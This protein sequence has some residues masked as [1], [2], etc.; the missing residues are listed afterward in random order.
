MV[1]IEWG[2]GLRIPRVAGQEALMRRSGVWPADILPLG[3]RSHRRRRH[4]GTQ[5]IRVVRTFVVLALLASVAAVSSVVAP[6]PVAADP[7]EIDITVVD[8]ATGDPIPNFKWVVNLDN[9]HDDASLTA[10]ASYSSV[11]AT[12]EVRDGSGVAAGVMLDDTVDPDRGYLVT[13]FVN[14]GVGSLYP[15]DYKIGGAHFR[16]PDAD[17]QVV[18][19]LQANPLPLATLK[20]QVFHDNRPVNGEQDV[21][22]E[23][24][25][26][27][28]HVT[29][30]DRVGEVTTDWFGNPICTQYEDLNGDGEFHFPDDLDADGNPVPVAGTGGVCLTGPDGIATIPNLGP[31]KYEA[32]AIPPDGQGWIQT[33]TIEGTLA[34]DAWIQEGASGFA[35]EPEAGFFAQVWF[36]F[37]HECRFGSTTDDCTSA[38][39]DMSGKTGIVKGRVRSIV[40]DNEM[41]P[42]TMGNPVASPY[43]AL[44]NIGGNDEQVWTG[45]GNVDGSFTITGVPAGLY[46]M[47]IWDQPIDHIIQFVTVRVPRDDCTT[48]AAPCTVDLGDLGVPPWFGKIAGT[49]YIDANEDGIRNPGE[50]SLPNQDLDT[51]FKD[52]TIQYTAFADRNGKYEF[53]EVF[54]LEHFAIAEVGY[55]RFKQTGAAAYKTDPFGNP[56]GYPEGTNYPDGFINQDLGLASLLQAEIT[57]AGTTNYI[58]WGKKAFAP[59]EN[60]GIVGIVFNATTRNELDARLQA[61]EDYEPGVPNTPV[62]LYAPE[63]DANGNPV[64]DADTG[65]IVKDHLAA[66]YKGGDGTD[67]W[68]DDALPKDCIPTPSLGRT[69]DQIQPPNLFPDCVELPSLF[70]QVRPGVFDGGYAFDLDCS[71]PDATDPFDPDQLLDPEADQC[72]PI[73]S[74]QWVVE[75]V[76][77]DGYGVVKEEDV[78]VFGG[79]VFEPAIPPPPCAGAQHTVHVVDDPADANFDPDDPSH[80]TGV[81]NPDFL[82]T[83]SPLAPNGGSPYEGQ[84]KPLCNERLVDLADG[85]N[86]NSDFFVFTDVPQPGRI[87]GVLLD[88]L[89]LELDPASP[90][91]GEKRG[92]PNAPIGIRDFTGRLVTTVYSDEN[93]YWEVLL[94][95]TGTYNCPLP[96][97]P[98]P[99]MYYVVGNDPGDIQNPDPRYDPNYQTLPL[100]FEVWPATTTYADVAT[101]PITGFVQTPGTQFETP[102]RC[103]VAAETPDV[104]AVSQPYGN[105]GDSFT[106]NGTGF[107]ATEGTVKLGSAALTV[108]SW[109]DTQIDVTVPG[110]TTPGPYQLTVT[111]SGGASGATGITF[112]VL[113][114][115]YN[116]PQ[117]HVGEGQTYGTVQEALDAAQDGD[118]VLVHPGVYNGKFIL[119]SNVKLQGYGPG[120]TV[121][122]GLLQGAAEGFLTHS[123]FDAKVATIPHDGP[124]VPWGQ[125]VTVLATDGQFHSGYNP[126]I[127]GFMVTGGRPDRADGASAGE[128]GGVYANGFA[129]NLEVSNN[130]V[131]SNGGT[132]GGG[133]IVGLP[134]AQ[135]QGLA[136]NQND[137]VHIHHNRVLNN[138]GVILAGGIALFNGA[139]NYEVDHNVICGNYS[140]EY[141]AG[142]SHWG[143]S[144]GGRVHD[145][146]LLFNYAFDEGGGMMVAGEP[147]RD[148]NAVSLGS[149]PVT[150][151]RNLVQG[152]VSN[153]DGGGFRVLN[154]VQWRIRFANNM[155]VNNMATDT[156]G[157]IALD[158]AL[159]V[160]IVNNTLARNV[161]TATAEDADRTSCSPPEFGTCPHGAGLVSERHSQ[162]LLDTAITP[163]TKPPYCTGTVNCSDNFTNPALFNN[164]FWQNEAFYLSGSADLFDGG[165]TSAG[166]IDYDVLAPATGHFHATSSDCTA[167]SVHCASGGADRNVFTD[168]QFVQQVS[169]EFDALAFAGDPSFITIIIRSTPDDPQGNYHV[170]AGSP[171]VNAG[172]N[173]AGGVAAPCDDFDGDGRPNGALWDIGADEQPGAGLCGVTPPPA[174]AQLYFSTAG[175]TAVPGVAGP[176][177]NADVYSWDGTGFAR[178]FDAAG[179]GSAGLPGG[180]DVDALVVADSDTFFLSFAANGGTTVPGITGAVQD[181]DVVRYDAGTW[182]LYFD[183]SDVG[184]GDSNAEDVDAFELLADGTVAVSTEG[185]PDVPGIAGEADADLLRC[186]GTFVP[187]SSGASATTTCTW[188]YYVD[189]SDVGLT[190]GGE[191]VDAA[192]VAAG[193]VYLST[194]GG[195]S[196]SG[197]SG[198]DEDVFRCNS[199]TIGPATACASF[200]MF[201]DGSAQGITDNLDAIDVP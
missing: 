149:G 81:Y 184:L 191:D 6:D 158:D 193:D 187:G 176:Y 189:G 120:A 97:G 79:D 113:G 35:S 31:D 140:A 177:D 92:I 68:Y 63:L 151:E 107:G 122:N 156:G 145:N 69:P 170:P 160:E 95:S 9:S 87:R 111:G 51:R 155:V 29:I 103:A 101:I 109:S 183:G 26:A 42:L 130:L 39:A 119:H 169:T 185:I 142:I 164:V 104:R 41:K 34:N 37:V 16:M 133:V 144:P 36:G 84:R 12:G 125:T 136:D 102:P 77:A 200:S 62:N 19:E 80:T 44:T 181:E 150:V 8:A 137:N 67:S 90:L 131:Q 190:A 24:G 162:A 194:R 1:T 27:G 83:T 99:A 96:A 66:V 106:I 54:E 174:G 118:L 82:A 38:T 115:G 112:H 129:R 138:G 132:A 114:A 171:V 17:G 59:G 28:F 43:I 139:E 46:Q 23:D 148:P 172:T 3:A 163:Q 201:F 105:A 65:E 49:T 45:R 110:G 14:D 128:G 178:V 192:A 180:A 134:T 33:A 15:T 195:F 175:S 167:A 22:F 146:Q 73:P 75:V 78:N 11:A 127:D 159:N 153:D 182:S 4:A 100:V 143:L 76:P 85:Q 70:D 21:G 179:T 64:Y 50:A 52:G 32:E 117:R 72:V 116:P 25:L 48:N 89:T 168:P 10:P 121:L 152:N 198:L 135:M 56:V 71:N 124:P 60:G 2:G 186:A 161:S 94:P 126:Q 58:D 30:A 88:D 74:G 91:Y 166:Y 20:V 165:L 57:W 199:V 86:A 5:P 93:G 141:G 98:C 61:N 47:A 40:L 13:A 157:G 108:S 147:N 53:P 7:S 123:D 154:G 196:V 173:A 55:G 188:T 197:L 18:V